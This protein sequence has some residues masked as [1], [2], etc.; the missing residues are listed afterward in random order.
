MEEIRW[1]AT[2]YDDVERSALWY[3]GLGLFATTLALFALWQ[4]NFLFAVFVVMAALT[5]TALSREKAP[6][7]IFAINHRG[8]EVDGIKQFPFNSLAGF[9]IEEPLK[10]GGWAKL[11]VYTKTLFHPS[12]HIAAPQ[13]KL[14]EI[15]SVLG[16]RLKEKPHED[17]LMEELLKLLKL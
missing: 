5:I 2:E 16:G 11:I 12:L 7:R 8:L 6:K 9:S 14:G 4:E 15:R 10:E 17:S 1:E 13:T 3:M